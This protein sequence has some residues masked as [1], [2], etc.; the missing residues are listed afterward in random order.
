[1]C[2]QFSTLNSL[3]EKYPVTHTLYSHEESSNSEDAILLKQGRKCT[4]DLQWLV[5]YCQSFTNVNCD[6]R[7][8]LCG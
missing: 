6:M 5:I 3:N 7:F 8:L 2:F 1:M 4:L